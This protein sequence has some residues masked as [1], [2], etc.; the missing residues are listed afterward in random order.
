MILKD[1]PL[2]V[3]GKV[4]QYLTKKRGLDGGLL[5]DYSVGETAD[6][7][8][9]SLAYKWRPPDWPANRERA[10]FEFCKVVKVDRPNGKK[11][12]WRD[13]KGGKNILFG[14]ESAI[15]K[16]AQAARGELVISEGEL[17]AI[18][19]AHNGFAA[20]SVPGGAK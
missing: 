17:D 18:S 4:H 11:D 7:E 20:V 1:P 3:D 13:P 6:G 9:Y 12:E 8:A 10:H 16:A 15:V 19:W 5:V 2:V 14:M